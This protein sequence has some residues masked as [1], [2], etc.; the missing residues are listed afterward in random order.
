MVTVNSTS[1]DLILL[2]GATVHT[3]KIKNNKGRT[4]F[5]LYSKQQN[6]GVKLH[7]FLLTIRTE[8]QAHE[9]AQTSV[10]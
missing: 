3:M 5:S 10:R 1:T 4:T 8:E 2:D 7:H 6:P 9:Q